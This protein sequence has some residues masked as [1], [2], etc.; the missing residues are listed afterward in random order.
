MDIDRTDFPFRTLSEGVESVIKRMILLGDLP[1]GERINEVQL[2]EELNMSRGPI[3]EALRRLQSEGLVVYHPHRGTFVATLTADDAEE[4]YSLRALLEVEAVRIA[5]P[6]VRQVHLDELEAIVASFEEARVEA[7]VA[8]IIA[9]DLDFHHVMV[10]LANRPRLF[11]MFKSLDTQ[12]GVMFISIQDKAPSRIHQLSQMHQAL[13]EALRSRD[14]Q[15]AVQ[16]F[17]DHY[18]SASNVLILMEKANGK[19]RGPSQVKG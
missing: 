11:D 5:L 3:R 9:C 4:V 18:L 8:R 1:P 2:S 6:K 14:E 17:R 10:R 15:T 19:V 12:L 13:V 7:N 16:A